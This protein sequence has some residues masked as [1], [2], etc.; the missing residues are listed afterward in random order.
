MESVSK[1]HWL[2]VLSIYGVS[3]LCSHPETARLLWLISGDRPFSHLHL[4][5]F[6]P[7]TGVSLPSV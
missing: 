6:A 5:G 1:W 2:I 4:I 3:C 7:R